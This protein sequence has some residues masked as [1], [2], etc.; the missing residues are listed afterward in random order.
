MATSHSL[1]FGSLGGP[2]NLTM[3]RPAIFQIPLYWQLYT[4]NVDPVYK[5]FYKPSVEKI[6]Q[7]ASYH[8]T[9]LSPSNEALLFGIYLAAIT[10]ISAAKVRTTFQDSKE[11]LLGRYRFALERALSHAGLVNTQ[12]LTTLQAFVLLIICLR[13]N[14]DSR[15]LWTLVGLAVRLA[16]GMGLQH[17]GTKFNMSPLETEIRR[18]LVSQSSAAML[19]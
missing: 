13:R 16:V 19:P 2:I 6:I 18:R 3:L 8:N 11:H 12:E 17:D 1:L 5:F 10:S 14:E 15:T 4:E 9:T 7:T